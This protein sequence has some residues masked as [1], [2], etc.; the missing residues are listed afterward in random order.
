M[1]S[2]HHESPDGSSEVKFSV[3]PSV[4]P[5]RPKR[6]SKPEE[7]SNQTPRVIIPMEQPAPP[8]RPTR[9]KRSGQPLQIWKEPSQHAKSP[10]KR[11]H[12][13]FPSFLDV[14]RFYTRAAAVISSVHFRP[15]H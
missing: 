9:L 10:E 13:K 3:V 8:V 1:P 2:H 6:R 14:A 7:V 15:V 12:T 11:G 5:L 4:G